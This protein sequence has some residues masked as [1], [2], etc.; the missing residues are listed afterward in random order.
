[1]KVSC[2]IQPEQAEVLHVEPEN[3]KRIMIEEGIPER[4]CD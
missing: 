4:D 1:M 3:Q 2:L